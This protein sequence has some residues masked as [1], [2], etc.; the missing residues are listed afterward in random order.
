MQT[1]YFEGKKETLMGLGL[2]GRGIGDA[3]YIASS[4]AKEVIVT[5][6]KTKEELKANVKTAASAGDEIKL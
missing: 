2:L 5:D 1:D 3:E 4:G 6:L